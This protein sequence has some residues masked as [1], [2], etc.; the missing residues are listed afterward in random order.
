MARQKK[1]QKYVPQTKFPPNRQEW[2]VMEKAGATYGQ[3][4]GYLKERYSVLREQHIKAGGEGDPWLPYWCYVKMW[5]DGQMT[6][7]NFV[8]VLG[9]WRIKRMWETAFQHTPQF[10][11]I[12][13]AFMA[14]F[15]SREDLQEL[16]T[17]C[18]N[19]TT[20]VYN[21][22]GDCL[23]LSEHPQY[24][25][26]PES[27][28][29][30]KSAIGRRGAALIEGARKTPYMEGDLVLLRDLGIDKAC[31]PLRIR[32]WSTPYYEGK[33]TPDKTV[34]R[35]GTVMAVTDKLDV[36]WRASKGSKLIKIMWM[37]V[38]DTKIVEV[39]ERFLKWHM[40]P[41]LK[42]GLKQREE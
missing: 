31:D 34:P 14:E 27:Y 21:R 8:S 23:S 13:D 2:R 16:Y 37:G 26:R 9:D 24:K 4:I 29:M 35:I 33:R 11:Q 15:D 1:V 17:L 25:T 39:P 36:P 41:T 30:Y 22:N 18:T 12:N 42:N 20:W 38:D 7:A 10:H 40:R 3:L 28:A 19:D 6:E 32:K 5:D